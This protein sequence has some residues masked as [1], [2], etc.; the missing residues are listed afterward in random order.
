VRVG[1]RGEVLGSVGGGVREK[2]EE[3]EEPRREA[4]PRRRML[5]QLDW[6]LQ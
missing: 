1:E 5:D 4:E 2:E 6:R 3:F